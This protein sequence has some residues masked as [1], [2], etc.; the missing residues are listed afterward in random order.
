MKV[1]FTSQICN[2]PCQFFISSVVLVLKA[3]QKRG[4]TAKLSLPPF[5]NTFSSFH[6]F[7]PVDLMFASFICL[8]GYLCDFC[9]VLFTFI[10][11]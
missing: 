10:L 8:S 11:L 4:K 9:L 5:H 6:C 1:A 2:G 3:E 7:Y